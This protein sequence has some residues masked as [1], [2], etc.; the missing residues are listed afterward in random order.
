MVEAD[1][2]A[3]LNSSRGLPKISW[4][5]FRARSLGQLR[6][7]GDWRMG[8]ETAWSKLVQN[9]FAETCGIPNGG[10]N[11]VRLS[12]GSGLSRRAVSATSAR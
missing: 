9:D 6:F 11:H 12:Q 3:S 1:L 7:P 4:T 8:R 2:G 10:E 5:N